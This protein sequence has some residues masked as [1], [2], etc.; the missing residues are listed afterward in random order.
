[1]TFSEFIS[2]IF[3]VGSSAKIIEG[4]LMREVHLYEFFLAEKIVF[5][6]K[7]EMTTGHALQV[8]GNG[9]AEDFFWTTEEEYHA[10]GKKAIHLDCDGDSTN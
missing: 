10:A 1:M 3:P 6:Y 4:L 2:S 5:L 8:E 7:K 9:K